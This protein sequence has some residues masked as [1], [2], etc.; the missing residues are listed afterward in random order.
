MGVLWFAA[1]DSAGC[2]VQ[3]LCSGCR[4]PGCTFRV[5]VLLAMAGC[6]RACFW[7]RGLAVCVRRDFLGEWCKGGPRGL[8]SVC[9]LW[10]SVDLQ[11][12]A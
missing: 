9:F 7:P 8:T 3:I 12:R 1:L 11:Q 4:D 6:C 2:K 5:Q 10:H